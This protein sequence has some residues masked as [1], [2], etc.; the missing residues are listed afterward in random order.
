[1][2]LAL[3]AVACLSRWSAAMRHRVLALAF[4]GAVVVGPLVAVVPAWPVLPSPSIALGA[5]RHRV[6]GRC[7]LTGDPSAGRG[8]PRCAAIAARRGADRVGAWRRAGFREARWRFL[9]RPAAG[10]PEPEHRGRHMGPC[11]RRGPRR[12]RPPSPRATGSH[13]AGGRARHVRRAEADGARA[14]Q[15]NRLG[16][17]TRAR[18]AAARAGARQSAGTGWCRCSRRALA[19]LFWFNPLFWI[20]LR[21]PAPRERVRLR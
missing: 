7:R 5:G 19:P 2:A 13:G 18:G 20:A 12:L 16:R 21:P 9:V 14:P 6:S 8:R 15:R 3:A 10:G 11:A 1:M 4:C 17:R